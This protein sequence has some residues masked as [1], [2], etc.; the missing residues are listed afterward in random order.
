MWEQYRWQIIAIAAALVAQALLTAGL[1]YQ[2]SRRHHAEAEARRRVAELAYLSRHAA[3]GEMSASIAHEIN[4]PLT[5][6]VLS[7]NVGL[8]WLTL[9]TPNLEEVSAALKRIVSDGHRASQVIATIRAMF[10]KETST[11]ALVDVNDVIREVLTLLRLEL[12]EGKVSV[13]RGLTDGLPEVTADRIQLVQVVLNL[14]RNANDAMMSIGDRPRILR[15]RSAADEFGN[16]LIAIEDSGTGVDP[17]NL[18]RVFEPFFTT[19]PQGMGMGL[20]ICR[21]IIEDHGGQLSVAIAK[22]FGSVFQITLPARK[23][24]EHDT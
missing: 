5:A 12:E 21:S 20:S 4:Q 23:E 7:G 8:R 24:A 18:D 13:R 6:I 19:K 10:K 16:V 11:R 2:R 14:V 17:E 22:P 15:V 1:M 9:A 3:A